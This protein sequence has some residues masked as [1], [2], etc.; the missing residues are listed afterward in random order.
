MRF[1]LYV[2]IIFSFSHHIQL[3]PGVP[4]PAG[5][6]AG[7]AVRSRSVRLPQRHARGQGGW[8]RAHL[9][10]ASGPPH[11]LSHHLRPGAATFRRRLWGPEVGKHGH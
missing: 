6:R 10:A 4:T 9:R 1:Y 7:D 2:F 8:T 3:L 5:R 11:V